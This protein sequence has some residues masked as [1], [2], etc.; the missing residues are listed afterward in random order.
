M[1]ERIIKKIMEELN[2]K[3]KWRK[4]DKIIRQSLWA[5]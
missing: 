3:R 2:A 4:I 1:M 5:K